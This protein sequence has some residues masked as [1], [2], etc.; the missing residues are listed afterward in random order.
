MS[1]THPLR[2]LRRTPVFAAAAALTL[3]LGIGSVAAAF[4]IVY[5]VLLDPLPYGHPD[6]LVSVGLRSA[7]LPRIQQPPAVYLT[8]KRFA[9]RI[10]E[11]G[12]YRTG[13][14]NI[15]ATGGVADP[16]RVTATWVTASMIPLLQ[17]APILGRSF[18]EDEDRSGAPDVAVIGESVWRSYFGASPDVLG[19]TLIVNS[20]PRRI[21]GVMPRRFVFPAADTK[22]WL[23]ARVDR[24]ATAMGDFAYWGVARL[25]PGTSARDA[26]RELASVLPRLAESFPR[27]GSGSPT[28]SWLDQARPAPVVVPLLDEV[29]HGIARTL[30]LVAA[31]A[32]LVLFVALANVANLM[33]IRAD[34]RRLEL[35][36]REALGAS[37][38]RIATHFLGESLALATAA[39]SAALLMAW[40]AVRALVAFGP[41]DLPRLAELHVGAATVVF[42]LAVS[43]GAALVCTIVPTVR[44]RSAT[45]SVDL[46]DGGRGE[47]AGRVRQRLRSTI[48][49]FQL[50]VALAVVAGSAV[51]LRTFERL[52]RERP[53]F[54]AT[55]VATAWTQLPF[56]RY[57]DSASVAFYATLTES[58]ARLPGVI[59][60]GVTTRLPLGD[61]D[62]RQLSFRREDGRAP[63]VPIV[64]IGGEYFASMRIPLLA[65]RGFQPL[66]RQRDGEIVLSRRAV[67]TLFDGIAASAAIG[68]RLS[69]APSGPTY[70]VVGVVGD[71]RDHDLAT[72]PAATAY[73][74]QAVPIDGR[75]EPAARRTMALVVR[76]AGPAAGIVAPVRRIVRDLDPTVPLFDVETMGDVVRASTAR[77]SLVL[78]VMTS[79][80]AIT[81]LLGAIGLY[82]VMAYMVALRTR[83]LGIRIALG[84]DPGGLARSVVLRAQALVAGG[85][86]GGLVLYALVTPVLRGF[87]YGVG[88]A[89][90]VTLCGATVAL[91]ATASLASWLPARRA[92]RVDPAVT[93]RAE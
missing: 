68:R 1:S 20:V 38:L 5:G 92:A 89:D 12:F 37:R 65:G 69:L 61:G 70:T 45:L 78:A 88:A 74:P 83:E 30:W 56:A 4:A 16:A 35:A 21:V 11:I 63:L 8:Y 84:A 64:A 82:G 44:I 3:A 59:A 2:S 24:D 23:P 26:E 60:A 80:A 25:A 90:P 17:V 66:D 48:A 62:A 47:T 77:L 27:L 33:S 29:T 54:E 76:T 34:A 9:R 41:A 86:F 53:G 18:T 73:M 32:G 15:A 46:R 7:E 71:V 42:V 55:N 67:E 57:D 49:A 81:L 36:V 31:A 58:V 52:I 43:V 40:G 39:G 19:R 72:P 79:A 91:L 6:R 28:T 50:A 93:L 85:V 13:N 14:A 10:D 87:L 51:L 22:L 75:T